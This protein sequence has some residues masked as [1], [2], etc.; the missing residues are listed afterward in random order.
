MTARARRRKVL[1]PIDFSAGTR[2]AIR[3]LDVLV[4]RRPF[5]VHLVHVLE[6]LHFA[7]PP[8]PAWVD[9]LV[10]RERDARRALDRVAAELRRRFGRSVEIRHHVVAAGS[11]PDA[12][13]KLADKLG[14]ELI[15]IATRG[16]TGLPHLL[17]GSVAERVI[18]H[19][20][21]PVLALPL[22]VR[23]RRPGR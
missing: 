19:A 7:A 14:V 12:I 18:R 1:L 5:A 13:C 22:A 21:R 15:V 9:D 20:R 16:R 11:A 10:G 4:G 17:L 3:G 6:P 8:A 23:T 2:A